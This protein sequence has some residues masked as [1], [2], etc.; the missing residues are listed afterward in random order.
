MEGKE[1]CQALGNLHKNNQ[2]N[3]AS[4][5]QHTSNKRSQQQKQKEYLVGGGFPK[6]SRQYRRS[7]RVLDKRRKY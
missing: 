6:G 1:K 4:S 2:D 3:N 5:I 7:S